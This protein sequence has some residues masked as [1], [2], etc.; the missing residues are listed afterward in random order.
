MAVCLLCQ[1]VA[2]AIYGSLIAVPC[3]SPDETMPKY[4]LPET[5]KAVVEA[6]ETVNLENPLEK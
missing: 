2:E 4:E 5:V 3:Q 6:L 1:I